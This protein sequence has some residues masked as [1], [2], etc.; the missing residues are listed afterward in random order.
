MSSIREQILVA[1][2]SALSAGP[3]I[4]STV[5]RSRL[6]AFARS[7]GLTVWV[8]PAQDSP[9]ASNT[10]VLDWV[11]ML[12]VGIIARGLIPDQ[13]ADPVVAAVH[14]RMMADQTLGGLS[15]AIEPR[16]TA[17]Q[18]LDS[19]GGAGVVTMDFA[20]AY[21]TQLNTIEA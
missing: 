1:V 12:R 2:T 17:W 15:Y 11:L 16:Q 6:V 14:A 5:E 21:R 10:Y 19:D 3:A 13:I 7:A 8:E 4:A 9:T 20:I 18:L